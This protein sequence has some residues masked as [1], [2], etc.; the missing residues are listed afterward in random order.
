MLP[1]KLPKLIKPTKLTVEMKRRFLHYIKMDLL[2]KEEM[3]IKEE[4]QLKEV[5]LQEEMLPKATVSSRLNR[6][7]S[8]ASSR[9]PT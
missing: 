6:H 5:L 1:I 9:V 2:I 8:K 3:L 7:T 4:T